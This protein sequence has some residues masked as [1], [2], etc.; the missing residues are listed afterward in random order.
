MGL[1]E[2][3]RKNTAISKFLVWEVVFDRVVGE[4]LRYDIQLEL[5]F[6]AEQTQK[7]TIRIHS[8]KESMN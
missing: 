7:L 1:T 4:A 5:Y 6:F 8:L 2:L 3:S